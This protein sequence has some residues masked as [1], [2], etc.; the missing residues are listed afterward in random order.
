[1]N[2]I[3]SD[4]L[5]VQEARILLE[6]ALQARAELR[7][8]GQRRLDQVVVHVA[9]SLKSHVDE[10]VH[11][12]YYETD[13]GNPEDERL[14]L[15]HL[16][17]ELPKRLV[18]RTC[19]GVIERNDDER[20]SEVGIPKGITVALPSPWLASVVTIHNVLLAIKTGNPIIVAPNRRAQQ[21]TIKTM[22]LICEALDQ[23]YYPAG[24]VG[25]L[26]NCTFEGECELVSHDEVALVIETCRTRSCAWSEKRGKERFRGTIGNNPVFVEKTADLAY[27][28]RQIVASKSFMNGLLPGVEQ[29]L[30]VEH[31]VEEQMRRELQRCGAYFLSDE[32]AA[33]LQTVMYDVD[34]QPR[35]EVMGKSAHNLA[36]RAELTIPSDTKVLVVNKPYVSTASPY[37]AEKFGPVLSFYVEDDW[38][39]ACEKCIELILNHKVG[40]SLTIYSQ[41]DE[42]IRQFILRKPVARVLVN[43]ASGFGSVGIT[44]SLFLS[45]TLAEAGVGGE[46]S[47]NLQP[48]HY[49]LCRKAAEQVADHQKCFEAAVAQLE[50]QKEHTQTLG[51]T[52]EAAHAT[53]CQG[54]V[55]VELL[56]Q[57]HASSAEPSIDAQWF[58]GLLHELKNKVNG[59]D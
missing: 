19:V 41:D 45:Y 49:L 34:G 37:A 58:E 57:Q 31:H 9:Q 14:L 55:P 7:M 26:K 29:S 28:A 11:L 22:E 50:Q 30:V 3:D 56:A 4:L 1:M 6:G 2:I 59:L 5:S 21:T 36:C 40:H 25:Y 46:T 52:Y 43:T 54:C 33:R 48:K 51:N 8:T 32:E 24:G 10:L 42:V 35:K 39:H 27:A 47:S 17:D 38:M 20:L 16:L 15:A 53:P 18:P 23:V 13:Y 44:T 12:A